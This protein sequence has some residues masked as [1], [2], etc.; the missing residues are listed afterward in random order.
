MML[1]IWP[2]AVPVVAV[3]AAAVIIIIEL[4]QAKKKKVSKRINE[5][6]TY[7]S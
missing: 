4:P 6:F 7:I 5:Q 2:F 3:A 1:I